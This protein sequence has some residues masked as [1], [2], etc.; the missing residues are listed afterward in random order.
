MSIWRT[1]MK[2]PKGF[3][4]R[5]IRGMI[6]CAEFED[7]IQDYLEDT[8]EPRQKKV[9]EFHLRLCRECRDYLSAYQQ[10]LALGKAAFK[11]SDEIV[12]S[13]VPDDLIKA[14]LDAQSVDREFPDD[15]K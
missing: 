1:I 2:M 5:H 12:P 9:F 13:T 8:L 3:M 10:T 4:F 11:Q 6:S 14:I 15:Q 7:F